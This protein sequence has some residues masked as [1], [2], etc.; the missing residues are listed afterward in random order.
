MS[1]E[2]YLTRA[3]KRRAAGKA[4]GRGSLARVGR[5]LPTLRPTCS[6]ADQS[7][8]GCEPQLCHPRIV[9]VSY[10]VLRGVS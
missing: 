3:A 7:T 9:T 10:K 5:G 1:R 2:K 8:F 4:E 6:S